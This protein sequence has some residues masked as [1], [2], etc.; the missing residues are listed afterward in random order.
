MIERL[1]SALVGAVLVFSVPLSTVSAQ[2]TTMTDDVG[3]AI[4]IEADTGNVLMEKNSEEALP[5][6]SMTKIMT[7]LL[8]ME[9][10]KAENLSFED[11]VTTS[12]YA[13]SMGGSQIFL[14]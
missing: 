5:P 6:A 2:E 4:L 3:S 7:M 10:I 14:E 8:I 9:E 12:E 13:A 1:V 11:L